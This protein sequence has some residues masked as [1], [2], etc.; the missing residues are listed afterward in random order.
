M[1]IY[2]VE[3]LFSRPEWEAE[4]NAWYEG[5]LKVLMGVH[6]FRS[7]QRF[8]SAAAAPRYM[9]MYTVDSP[10][11]FDSAVYK[12]AGGGGTNS[13][14]FREAYQIWIRNLFDSAQPIPNVGPQDY[15]LVED[16]VDASTPLK[17]SVQR[18]VCTGFHKTTPYRCLSIVQTPPHTL[19]ANALCYRAITAQQGQLYQ[20]S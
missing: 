4:W 5:N 19:T 17:P 20:D 15:L 8:R 16:T 7:G 2:M 9:A 10:V 18:M 13:Q 1:T 3:H 12:A 11:V 14:R 6:G